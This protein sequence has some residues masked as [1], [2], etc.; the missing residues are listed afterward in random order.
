[1]DELDG[2]HKTMRGARGGF[3][4]LRGNTGVKSWMHGGQV[5]LDGWNL[6]PMMLMPPKGSGIFRQYSPP[7]KSR[8]LEW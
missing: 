7:I 1:M 5:T 8:R 4:Q 6:S 2:I 3:F